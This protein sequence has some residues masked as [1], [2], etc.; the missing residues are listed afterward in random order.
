M[1]KNAIVKDD[2]TELKTK[3]D[4]LT[5][6]DIAFLRKN[7]TESYQIFH[8]ITADK[9]KD[10]FSFVNEIITEGKEIN[11][12][13]YIE[14]A[15]KTYLRLKTETM[16]KPLD[17]EIHQK[18]GAR[19]VHLY[20][21]N[22]KKWERIE[23]GKF[24]GA[25]PDEI[26]F[27][28]ND[29]KEK[30]RTFKLTEDNM[31]VLTEMLTIYSNPNLKNSNIGLVGPRGTG[32]NTLGYVLAGL[33]GIP[34][35][36]MSLHAHINEKDLRER[37]IIV[38]D[39]KKVKLKIPGVKEP[40]EVELP[41][42]RIKSM[43][44]EVYE[45]A[46]AGELVI[47][48]EADKV[49][50]PGYLSGLNSVL[51][52]INEH[53]AEM[54]EIDP[55]F[56]VM[57]FIN[58]HE[59]GDVQGQDL[60]MYAA[61]F[62]DRV[63]WIELGYMSAESELDYIMSS[64][65]GDVSGEKQLKT[66][67][68][69]MKAV[70][71]I[72]NQT[73]EAVKDQRITRNLSTRGVVRI[74]KH[75]KYYPSDVKY[76]RSVFEKAYCT[77]TVEGEKELIDEIIE[78]SGLPNKIYPED[79][80]LG[81]FEYIEEN[82]RVY[83]T[84]GK[85]EWKVKVPVDIRP[86][87]MEEAKEKLKTEWHLSSNM[88]IFWNWMKDVSM[89]NNIM[90]L[91]IPGTGKTELMLYFLKTV[92]C[93]DKTR[94]QVL[95]TGTRGDDIFGS[96][97]INKG[98]YE[99]KKN[100]LPLAMGDG[101]PCVVDEADKPR[102]ETAMSSTNNIGEFGQVTL[103]DGSVVDGRKGF[104]MVC[105]GNLSHKGG[106]SSRKI[107]GE[108]MDRHS[109]YIMN[110]LSK[111]KIIQMLTNYR[112][113]YGY[114]IRDEFIE[115]LALYN[116]LLKEKAEENIL[117]RQ[118][119][120]RSLEKVID[121]VGR[122]KKA[123]FDISK[124]FLNKFLLSDEWHKEEIRESITSE[125]IDLQSGRRTFN[126]LSFWIWIENTLKT[127]GYSIDDALRDAFM[128]VKLSIDE[129]CKDGDLPVGLNEK[130]FTRLIK[131]FM[132]DMDLEQIVELITGN[133]GYEEVHKR[134]LLA[135]LKDNLGSYT[136]DSDDLGAETDMPESIISMVADFKERESG[137][138]V[139]ETQLEDE[140]VTQPAEP[141]E[142][143]EETD[144]SEETLNIS[145]LT[146]DERMI[147]LLSNIEKLLNI[148]NPKW[149]KVI[150]VIGIL[151]KSA[152]EAAFIETYDLPDETTENWKIDYRRKTLDN[153][154]EIVKNNGSEK[155]E[156]AK[157]N[158]KERA[159][160]AN[161][162]PHMYTATPTNE[163][164][165][166]LDIIDKLSKAQPVFSGEKSEK[167]VQPET[168]FP[169][170]SPVMSKKTV[171]GLSREELKLL[172]EGVEVAGVQRNSK[173]V[174]MYLKEVIYGILKISNLEFPDIKREYV[175][176]L[177][178]RDSEL[179]DKDRI[180]AKELKELGLQGIREWRQSSTTRY[181]FEG[182]KISKSISL[183]VVPYSL[184]STLPLINASNLSSTSILLKSKSHIPS[185]SLIT[186]KPISP[187]KVFLSSLKSLLL[188]TNLSNKFFNS[189]VLIV[190]PL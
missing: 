128:N 147:E 141:G 84:L 44:S 103:P 138:T 100:E 71:K 8:K 178:D 33:V 14:K 94:Y 87:E 25:L 34:V 126:E 132:E 118:P 54:K 152:E 72:A 112:N 140:S 95:N 155:A 114:E 18:T 74:A 101:V 91:G 66:I 105:L 67:R 163:V 187:F 23:F 86:E 77:E 89:G 19:K 15:G 16:D 97:E 151:L 85:D 41:A 179:N 88:V 35:R 106:T 75:L 62:V 60:T 80:G 143:S 148:K 38:P 32:K 172:N 53:L 186:A 4:K 160:K 70:I 167:K 22:G 78:E 177:L 119:S 3:Y 81:E 6:D 113:R 131:Y 104:I 115:G 68:E 161:S 39:T 42:D 107:S 185:I 99:F 146:E 169:K 7:P 49:L 51:T 26:G 48:D 139:T 159:N 136:K 145:E 1:V 56:R 45:A 102:D 154:L 98:I 108:V 31:D 122:N 144:T 17:V 164:L 24:T 153:M 168:L 76:F 182:G 28:I 135:I 166:S 130:R 50:I 64:V 174:E 92:L 83:C 47:I 36:V 12:F 65:F 109:V 162:A 158:I 165:D 184:I 176:G 127:L 142:Q 52:R 173:S 29:D 171:K 13:G 9:Y 129:A 133:L 90:V 137:E 69:I 181:I 120:M 63:N 124:T 149:K 110:A 55:A 59:G 123:Y 27:G 188:I 73:R 121:A 117:P 40:A 82:G 61:D 79:M 10:L 180:R 46:R 5:D 30:I 190:F 125:Q 96:W 11:Y 150:D 175:Q 134:V 183:T 116:E 93:K 57:V 170:K 189:E 21:K 43:L 37:K 111:E 156:E 157:N 2:F 20:K 58:S